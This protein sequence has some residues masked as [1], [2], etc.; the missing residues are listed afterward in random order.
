LAIPA[1]VI[2]KIAIIS[3]IAKG[4]R[5]RDCP[6]RPPPAAA[7]SLE[8]RAM[9]SPNSPF[10]ANPM[11]TARPRGTKFAIVAAL[12]LLIL[13]AAGGCSK[14][15]SSQPAQ[16]EAASPSDA[17]IARVNG[18]EIRQSD[19]ALAED[20]FN[21]EQL[22]AASPD[23]KREQL[24]AYL[25]DIILASQ[26][27]DQ[28]NLADNPEFKR[29]QAFLRNKLLM[30]ALLQ[31]HVKSAVTEEEM[32]KVYDEAVKP[33]G[34]EEEVRARHI[35][36]ETEDEAKS[37]LEELNKGGDFAALATEKSKDP[38]AVAQGGDLGYFT[39]TQMVPEFAEVAFKMYPG[40][41]SNPV[42]TQFGWH[43]IKLEDRRNRK[44][45]EFEQ[46]KDQIEAFIARRAQTELVAQ[47]REGA[48]IERLDRPAPKPGEPAKPA[49]PM[50]K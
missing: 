21:P 38:T 7:A 20:D 2:V 19:L 22:H 12:A 11:F 35:L 25:T 47:L 32:R 43:I 37:I 23:V 31:A 14:N 48:K 15:S 4:E 9:T 36:V 1:H 42:K 49:E 27:A 44:P 41:L 33:M 6:T 5:L 13:P 26:A 18:I 3:A 8:D 39:K 28:R 17:V 46:V 29:R 45:P 10:C 50:K 30:G 34:A 16:P 24:I 40:Q